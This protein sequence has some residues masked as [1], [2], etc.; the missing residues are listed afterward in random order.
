MEPRSSLRFLHGRV[1]HFL[2]ATALFAV[3]GLSEGQQ[4]TGIQPVKPGRIVGQ[5]RWLDAQLIRPY[6]DAN[7]SVPSYSWRPVVAR[8]GWLDA[9]RSDYVP[10]NSWDSHH[11]VVASYDLAPDVSLGDTFSVSA[12]SVRLQ[13]GASYAFGSP[14]FGSSLQHVCSG[15]EPVEQNPEGRLCDLAEAVSLLDVTVRLSGAGLSRLDPAQPVSCRLTGLIADSQTPD[16]Q[17]EQAA[18]PSFVFS[19]ATLTGTGGT[20]Q[21]LVRAVP[22]LTLVVSCSAAVLSAS[23]CFVVEPGSSRA[24]LSHATVIDPRSTLAPSLEVPVLCTA[25]AVKGNLDV[26]GHTVERSKVW[27]GRQASAGPFQQTEPATGGPPFR[28]LFDGFPA[29]WHPARAWSVFDNRESFLRLPARDGVNGPVPV[30]VQQT[31]DLANTFVTRPTPVKGEMVLSDFGSGTLGSLSLG[32]L[33]LDH[34]PPWDSPWDDEPDK[35]YENDS[36][37]MEARGAYRPATGVAS[38]LEGLGRAQLKGA[39][40]AAT[41]K[42]SLAYTLHLGGL[43]PPSGAADGSNAYPTPWDASRLHLRLTPPGGGRQLMLVRLASPDLA[44]P[45]LGPSSAPLALPTQ[46]VCFGE[47]ELKLQLLPSLGSL[48]H[49]GASFMSVGPFYGAA[50]TSP[51]SGAQGQYWNWDDSPPA[52]PEARI[53][54]ALAAGLSYMVNP[55]VDVTLA[56]SGSSNW[57]SLPALTLPPN[58]PI[59][60]GDG[61]G[62]CLRLGCGSGYDAMTVEVL[63]ADGVSPAPDCV[64]GSSARFTV[65]VKDTAGVA[66]AAVRYALDPQGLTCGPSPTDLCTSSC[67]VDPQFTV[68]V[69]GLAPGTHH[70]VAC[71]GLA[72]DPLC[73]HH[74]AA[75]STLTLTCPPPFHVRL[76]P[77]EP[78][79]AATDGRVAPHLVASASGCGSSTSAVAA[80]DLPARFSPGTTLVSFGGGFCRTAVT[81]IPSTLVV[82]KRHRT[83]LGHLERFPL[84]G[85]PSIVP[86]ETPVAIGDYVHLRRGLNEAAV[87]G[88]S[89]LAYVKFPSPG[90]PPVLPTWQDVGLPAGPW[91]L[92]WHPIKPYLA[93]LGRT[94]TNGP[95]VAKV[96]Q[97]TQVLVTL[98]VPTVAVN[99]SQALTAI[100]WSPDGKRLALAGVARVS[101]GPGAQILRYVV[102]A[103]DFANA[104]T[105]TGPATTIHP[106][107]AGA[108][109][110]ELLNRGDHLLLA[111]NRT[112]WRVDQGW[113][114][115]LTRVNIDMAI[116]PE[117]NAVVMAVLDP[118]GNRARLVHRRLGASGETREGPLV[119]L[120]KP[121]LNE[122]AITADG[123][124]GAIVTYDNTAGTQPVPVYALASLSPTST[125]VSVVVTDAVGTDPQFQR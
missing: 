85:G 88:P 49:P 9:G 46:S 53:S 18:S 103:W 82:R 107:P 1:G 101:T 19:L 45:P 64:V 37:F 76:D 84:L 54:L 112:L 78:D 50:G 83:T 20:A 70:L 22:R 21:L 7:P 5:L 40:D 116:A 99:V 34:Y 110:H 117:G 55:S 25:G 17:W 98:P 15:V 111:T 29:G 26:V 32:P 67:P 39:Y 66:P 104:T 47:A 73:A 115:L 10:A 51:L 93:I 16:T 92:A 52:A 114:P 43:G 68:T 118:G 75:F 123:R 106:A 90:Q 58:G 105:A 12:F 89:G 121:G 77:G 2:L 13:D 124:F 74:A 57:A 61:L 38:G 97:G 8:R 102:H 4:C 80:D 72:S 96:V 91:Q 31:T 108:A 41:G 44:L 69:N 23:P 42:A 36:S 27:L 95:W 94:A 35:G 125:A 11:R 63:A 48:S 65:R 119:N 109:V 3:P 122:V 33:S 24:T 62:A 59:R 87:A 71:A 113:L 79:V 28:W 14:T 60:C 56:G 100:G 6:L 120:A 30:Q 86:T 81:V